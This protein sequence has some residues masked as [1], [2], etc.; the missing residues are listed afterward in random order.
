MADLSV[1]F[2]QNKER[3]QNHYQNLSHNYDDLWTHSPDFMQFLSKNVSAYL[4]LK[5]TDIF[6]DLRSK[7]ADTFLLKNCIKS[8]E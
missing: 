5:S 2:Y 8:G 1:N 4:D 3:V 7:Y 6:L